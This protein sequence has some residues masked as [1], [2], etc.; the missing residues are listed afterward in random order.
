MIKTTTA[1]STTKQTNYEINAVD[2]INGITQIIPQ[3]T[4]G[5]DATV[6]TAS[7]RAVGAIV[8][9]DQIY[10]FAPSSPNA[11]PVSNG[12]I[13]KSNNNTNSA[14]VIRNYNS[15]EVDN[16]SINEIITS[17]REDGL[18]ILKPDSSTFSNL[19]SIGTPPCSY[20]T[21]GATPNTPIL[22][23]DGLLKPVRENDIY[24][25][26][27]KP[28]A[29]TPVAASTDCSTSMV[30]F[31]NGMIKLTSSPISVLNSTSAD[32]FCPTITNASHCNTF[33]EFCTWRYAGTTG[34]GNYEYTDQYYFASN[35]ILGC[36]DHNDD[37]NNCVNNG[38][39]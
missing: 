35:T 24:F 23:A 37:E 1:N 31:V 3:G 14:A 9:S 4:D 15:A 30:N 28:H 29:C 22:S 5:T 8:S 27:S 13:S 17:I 25:K 21:S 16:E 12:I 38:C 34:S 39:C 32:I 10:V 6:T 18:M 2:F 19:S 36:Q 7:I 33:A 26:I 20:Q 11:N